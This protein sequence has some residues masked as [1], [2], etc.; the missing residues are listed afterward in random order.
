[1]LKG[2]SVAPSNELSRIIE[3]PRG[4][5]QSD[6][7]TSDDKEIKR[8]SDHLASMEH[9]ATGGV[10]NEEECLDYDKH[11]LLDES[12][13]DDNNKNMSLTDDKLA[14]KNHRRGMS[15]DETNN[16]SSSFH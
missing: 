13:R 4:A 1:M 12:C 3:G 10:E 15:N 2:R 14:L 9:R 5:E 6:A 8:A 11:R 16:L 7:P